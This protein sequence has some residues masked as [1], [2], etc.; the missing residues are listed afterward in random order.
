MEKNTYLYMD[1]L[2]I[3]KKF[4][5]NPTYCGKATVDGKIYRVNDFILV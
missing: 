5:D 2:E 1:S 3:S 4:L